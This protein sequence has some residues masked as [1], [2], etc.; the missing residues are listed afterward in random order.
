MESESES[1]SGF[2]AGVT[3]KNSNSMEVGGCRLSVVV[4]LSSIKALDSRFKI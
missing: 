1:E 3:V 2:A 4:V